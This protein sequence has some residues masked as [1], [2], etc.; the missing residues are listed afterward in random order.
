MWLVIIC[1]VWCPL[2]FFVQNGVSMLSRFVLRAASL[3]VRSAPE[4]RHMTTRTA[5]R[6]AAN[7][8]V[9]RPSLPAPFPP[10]P[11]CT[12]APSAEEQQST[13]FPQVVVEPVKDMQLPT[14]AIL[15]E[16]DES[17]IYNPPSALLENAV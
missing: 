8:Y 13:F 5:G 11:F 2:C 6:I 4:T 3:A 1:G 16:N 7:P 10:N 17:A 12:V 14:P 15:P 9:K